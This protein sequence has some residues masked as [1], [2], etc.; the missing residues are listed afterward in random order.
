M[1]IALI[2]FQFE[3]TSDHLFDAAY[4]GQTDTINGVS[5]SII[6]GIPI[7]LG[8]GFFKLIYKYPF[9]MNKKYKLYSFVKM[10]KLPI[11]LFTLFWFKSLIII[12]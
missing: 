6:M 12:E 2:Y 11:I 4:Y 10:N 3:K 1:L 7:N 9:N 5:E 8:T